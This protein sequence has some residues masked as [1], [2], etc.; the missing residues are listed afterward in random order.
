MITLAEHPGRAPRRLFAFGAE[1]A[2]I[3]GELAAARARIA[4]AETALA[5]WRARALA[6]ESEVAA[7]SGAGRRACSCSDCASPEAEAAP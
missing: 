7:A 5:A 2:A 4:E 6:A 3:L 1:L